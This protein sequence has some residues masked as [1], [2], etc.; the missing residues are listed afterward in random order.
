MH[1]SQQ[2][3]LDVEKVTITHVNVNQA[4]KMRRRT[5]R[6]HGRINGQLMIFLV[7]L[8]LCFLTSPHG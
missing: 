6:A 7:S 5:Y 1:K 2:S 4:P 8:L 3:N